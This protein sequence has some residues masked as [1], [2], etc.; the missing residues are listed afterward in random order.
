MLSTGDFC[1]SY[2]NAR[3]CG[4]IPGKELAFRIGD[5]SLTEDQLAF[6]TDACVKT[7]TPH[8]ILTESFKQVAGIAISGPCP[9]LDDCNMCTIY[10]DPLRPDACSKVMPGDQ[11]CNAIRRIA[12]QPGVFDVLFNMP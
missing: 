5:G 3:C 10:N 9:F 8:F 11:F 2:C 12:G 1:L 4:N 7:G 6:I